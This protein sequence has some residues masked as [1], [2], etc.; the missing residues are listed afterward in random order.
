MDLGVLRGADHDGLVRVH[1]YFSTLSFCTS[2]TS[3]RPPFCERP[4]GRVVSLL[5]L[6][7]LGPPTISVGEWSD[8]AAMA[9]QLDAT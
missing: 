8:A 7:A 6:L 1:A 5:D 4:W 3:E 2:K 9:V